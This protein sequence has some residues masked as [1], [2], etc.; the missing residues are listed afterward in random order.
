MHPCL[1]ILASAAAS[2]HVAWSLKSHPLSLRLTS[3]C[4]DVGGVTAGA[5]CAAWKVYRQECEA[6]CML[7]CRHWAARLCVR[8]CAHWRRHLG[9]GRCLRA[10]VGCAASFVLW[11][12]HKGSYMDCCR[13]W[14]TRLC[15]AA[16]RT[17]AEAS[18]GEVV[19]EGRPWNSNT[20]DLIRLARAHCL[21]VLHSTFADSVAQMAAEVRLL[22]FFSRLLSH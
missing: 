3:L 6:C 4:S 10:G 9:T 2:E 16:M 1:I 7:L 11:Q 14:A 5:I 17:L 20:V 8:P 13:H 22:R 12:V 21:L 18:G 15:V 19:F